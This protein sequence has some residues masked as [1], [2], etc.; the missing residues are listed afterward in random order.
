M[1]IIPEYSV[2]C[3]SMIVK[4]FTVVISSGNQLKINGK[5]ITKD[6][7][8]VEEKDGK[9]TYKFKGILLAPGKPRSV[10]EYFVSLDKMLSL[11][12]GAK[13]LALQRS[14]ITPT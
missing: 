4:N 8:S 7:A 5:T 11:V 14:G 3:D 13:H 9:L 12:P 6:N 10:E 2:N 1:N